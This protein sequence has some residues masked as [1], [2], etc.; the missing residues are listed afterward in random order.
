MTTP[1]IGNKYRRVN[2]IFDFLYIVKTL[3][4]D[5]IHIN[6]PSDI[7]SSVSLLPPISLGRM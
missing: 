2:K 1:Q 4:N 5:A 6:I 7:A 3:K